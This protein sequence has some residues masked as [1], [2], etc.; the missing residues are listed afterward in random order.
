MPPHATKTQAPRSAGTYFSLLSGALLLM[1]TVCAAFSLTPT[2]ANAINASPTVP[3]P[4]SW[5]VA[6]IAKPTETATALPT[7][8]AIPPRAP[9]APT[10]TVEPT[11]SL[12]MS[13]VENTATVAP[14]SQDQPLA[15]SGG[16]S[17]VVSISE[18][19]LYAYDNGAL[20]YS[21]VVS[22]G[23][24]NST[25][26]GTFH[27]LDKIPNAY[28]ATWNIWMPDWM[29]IY[30]A[31]TLENGIH[32]LPILPGGGRLWEGL[33]GTP[34]SYGCVVL[35]IDEALQL[36]NWADIGTPVEIRR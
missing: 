21:Y 29:G 4:V 31:G 23:S 1:L 7:A 3:A 8:T 28:G 36:Y 5:S 34:V 6:V 11:S 26:A 35:G 20:V 14:A 19:H 27:V 22:T 2:I 17:I 30:W 18:Q 15:D 25:R 33:L 12:S 32:A 16:K 9:V 13:I 10:D 24:G